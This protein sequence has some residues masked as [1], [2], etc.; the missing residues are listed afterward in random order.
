MKDVGSSLNFV[1]LWAGEAFF[2]NNINLK[3]VNQMSTVIC[4]T[5]N[6]AELVERQIQAIYFK[7]VPRNKHTR[8]KNIKNTMGGMP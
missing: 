6:Q 4:H 1:P 2:V 3:Y 5:N 8:K 7:C